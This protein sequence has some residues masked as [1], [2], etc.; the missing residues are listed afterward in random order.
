MKLT[1]LW[2]WFNPVFTRHI[3]NMTHFIKR[4]SLRD[5]LES[6]SAELVL[7]RFYKDKNEKRNIL[8]SKMMSKIISESTLASSVKLRFE[9]LSAE[10]QRITLLT[11]LCGSGGI[12]LSLDKIIR[13]EL[14]N[15][16]LI[17]LMSDEDENNYLYGFSD[18]DK[19]FEQEFLSDY[20]TAFAV[21]K[22]GI[23]TPFYKYRALNDL[24][25]VL[26]VAARNEL[27]LKK[28]G[29]L[30][31]AATNELKKITHISVDALYFTKKN[32]VLLF[33]Y[34]FLVHFAF[35]HGLLYREDNILRVSNNKVLQWLSQNVVEINEALLRAAID[36]CG[37][38]NVTLLENVLKSFRQFEFSNN[39]DVLYALQLLYFTG[40]VGASKIDKKINI[41]LNDDLW[42]ADNED[43]AGSIL[44]MPDFSVMIS[45]TISP[46]LLFQ[47]SRIGSLVK[48]DK[49]YKGKLDKGSLSDSLSGGLDGREIVSFLE[50]W[51]APSNVII[52]VQEWV[53]EFHRIS[54]D[55]GKFIFV[56]DK[57][58]VNSIGSHP[59][60]SQYIEEMETVK[61]FR[62]KP[63]YESRVMNT[64]DSF[65]FD[66]RS[67]KSK[68]PE[69]KEPDPLLPKMDRH[70]VNLKLVSD[71]KA[72][73]SEDTSTNYSSGGKYSNTLKKLSHHDTVQVID[74][75]ML[76]DSDLM[77]D[78]KGSTGVKKG[79]YTGSPLKITGPNGSLLELTESDSGKKV[80][81][82]IE[83]I[84]RIA[85]LD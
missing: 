82:V 65:G 12:K 83:D 62:I 70:S 29:E 10:A 51:R 40:V 55:D 81:L 46:A 22:E 64:L 20:V 1:I 4:Y 49:V 72:K 27:K 75:A 59:Q 25:A 84:Y 50:K 79:M 38:W 35:E 45:Q 73:V 56:S 39:P 18:L 2:D 66:I 34:K 23:Q 5:Y 41:T 15:S 33:V 63:G 11:Y 30:T 36:Y 77:I 85:V 47:V 9:Q 16:F 57:E 26:N 74:Y 71:F 78:Y 52:T 24:I 3:S 43:K 31:L 53:N 19:H 76:M 60:L 69:T 21:E 14:Q 54:I 6:L 7:E 44:F 32:S 17:Y 13:E 28:N 80:A 61:V 58:T 8:S 37:R 68:E 42:E 48:L 67:H